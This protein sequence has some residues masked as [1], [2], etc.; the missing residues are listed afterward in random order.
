LQW[1]QD[2]SEINGDNLSSIRWETRTHFRNKKREY[3]N[4][5][6]DELAKNSQNK[7]IRDQDS[8]IN[9]FKKGY[10]PRSNLV[11]DENGDLFA[12]SHNI[13]N[14]WKNSFYQ[15][16]NVHRVSDV[17]QIEIHTAEPLVP[18]EVEIAIAKLKKYKSSGSDQ[19][20]A[21]LIQAVGEILGSEIHKFIHSIWNKESPYQWK[22]SII[23]PFQKKGDK[24]D[25]NNYRGI[26]LPSVSRYSD[27]L[28]AGRPRGR[29]LSPSRFKNFHFSISS[30]P[31]LGP[32]RR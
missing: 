28:R 29:S 20:P 5:K 11:K 8:G 27:W 23:V 2:P 12:D 4:D 1:L 22:E 30:R 17:R 10:Q 9:K 21:E 32:T 18:F 24:T 25:C 6:T 13:L 3:L 7:N 16:L 15:L 31:A 14:S 26:S 19:I